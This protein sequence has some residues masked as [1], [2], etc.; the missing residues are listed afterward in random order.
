MKAVTD[1]QSRDRCLKFQTNDRMK[2]KCTGSSTYR[3]FAFTKQKN[4]N[5]SKM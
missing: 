5:I 3:G 4:N 1:G 2:G